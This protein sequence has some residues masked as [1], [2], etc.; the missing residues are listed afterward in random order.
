MQ[1]VAAH[2]L[3][4]IMTADAD[5]NENRFAR[6]EFLTTEVVSMSNKT[7]IASSLITRRE[8]LAEAACAAVLVSTSP[9][10]HSAESLLPADALQHR[11]R[12]SFDFEWK[13]LK[14][15]TQGA[16]LPDFPDAGWRNVDLPHDWSIEGPIDEHAPSGGP[17]G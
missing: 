13:F 9:Y 8:V 14:G 11:I 5:R 3:L 6:A 7:T 2:P 17:G 15:D 1:G 12:E 10:L 4:P 16:E